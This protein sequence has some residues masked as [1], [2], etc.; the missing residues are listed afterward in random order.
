MHL[1][2]T[3]FLKRA[4]YG[5]LSVSGA[6]RLARR[7]YRGKA[8]ILTYHGVLRR[9]GEGFR[10]RICIDAR[11]F[12]RQLSW[13]RKRYEV[14]PLSTLL[15]GLAGEVELPP[16]AVAITFDDGFLN[17]Y[18]VAFPILRSLEVPATIFLATGYIGDPGAMLWTDHVDSLVFSAR[19]PRLRVPAEGA[20]L[21]Y[22][23]STPFARAVTSEALRNHL[24]R[25]SPLEREEQIRALEELL[26]TH[27]PGNGNDE[28]YGFL[29]WDQVRVMAGQGIEF[30]SH[31]HSHAIL[32]TLSDEELE[33]EIRLSKQA[34]EEHLGRRCDLF[35]Y[36]NGTPQDF[37]PRDQE[38]LQRLGFRAALSQVR[39]FNAVGENLYGLRRVNV[40]R[41]NDLSYF[42][43]VVAGVVELVNGK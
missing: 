29:S 28:R 15:A 40:A 42:K 18:S 17:N 14:L 33:R 30:G 21:D 27:P 32:S 10:D 11:V 43:A 22:D 9:T 20:F 12:E 24:K 25:L 31:T 26:G 3:P 7:V 5:T 4:F 16:F 38:I 1:L 34:V 6:L 19:P 2:R 35:S 36:P 8:L 41:S 39:G 13:L 37:G 23:V